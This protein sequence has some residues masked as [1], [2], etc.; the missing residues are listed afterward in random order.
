[1][2]LDKKEDTIDFGF[3]APSNPPVKKNVVP[4]LFDAPQINIFENES[5]LTFANITDDLK[6]L[7]VA[8]IPT[9]FKQT[10]ILQDQ[11]DLFQAL[12]ELSATSVL[13]NIEAVAVD[14][15]N[16]QTD[17][18]E[19]KETFDVNSFFSS[20]DL[21]RL[22]QEFEIYFQDNKQRFV[23]LLYSQLSIDELAQE[24]SYY[25]QNGVDEITYKSGDDIFNAIF[26]FLTA[27]KLVKRAEVIKNNKYKSMIALH[28]QIGTSKTLD[29][30]VIN[31]IKKTNSEKIALTENTSAVNFV[32][33]LN[34]LNLKQEFLSLLPEIAWDDIGKAPI[35]KIITLLKTSDKH[36]LQN[37]YLLLEK[38]KLVA[39]QTA[40]PTFT[41]KSKV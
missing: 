9:N 23:D 32:E 2:S 7:E 31:I 40:S 30:P 4:S 21:G 14:N 27:D 6:Q 28:Q 15:S 39:K 17:N 41:I 3:M 29:L 20:Y 8:S 33:D 1:M 22:P 10:D 37:L 19:D 5:D 11:P 18:S 24:T 35:E 12:N 34:K 38:H 25:E 16:S 13:D 36:E 26:D